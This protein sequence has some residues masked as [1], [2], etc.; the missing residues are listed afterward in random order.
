[1]E[2]KKQ[3]ILELMGIAFDRTDPNAYLGI[4]TALFSKDYL[5][6]KFR[7]YSTDPTITTWIM[8]LRNGLTEFITE[9]KGKQRWRD[10]TVEENAGRLEL[11]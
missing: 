10:V 6:R 3:D 2:R 1:M 5:E 4:D 7:S 9:T 11:P 8:T